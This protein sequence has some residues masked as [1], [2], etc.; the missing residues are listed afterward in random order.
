MAKPL[1][2]RAG[3]K[4][5]IVRDGRLLLLRRRKD[6]YVWPGLWDLPGGGLGPGGTLKGNLTRE[7]FA[8]TG[9]R[10]RVGEPLDV[11]FGWIRPRGEPP[12]PSVVAC[13]RC[14]TRS[15]TEPRL[16]PEEHVEFRWVTG[17][18]LRSMR[19]IP[20]LRPAMERALGRSPR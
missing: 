20:P 15:K 18:E 12:F 16:D 17:L 6:L 8:E 9:F 1:W 3:A 4:G 13:Y 11:L 14:S 5:A 2:V 10:V 19:V 7:F